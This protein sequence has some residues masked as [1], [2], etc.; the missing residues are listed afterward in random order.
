TGGTLGGT[1]G[2]ALYSPCGASGSGAAAAGARSG[3]TALNPCPAGAA[4]ARSADA[5][6]ARGRL[7][8]GGGRKGLSQ[9]AGGRQGRPRDRLLTSWRPSAGRMRRVRTP[10]LLQ[11]RAVV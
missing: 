11:K 10:G 1:S 6:G 7:R 5:G 2:A 4:A 3:P 8:V 9:P